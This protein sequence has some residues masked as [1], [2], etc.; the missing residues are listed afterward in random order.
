[1][2]VGWQDPAAIRETGLCVWRSG[3][4]PVLDFKQNGDFLDGRMAIFWTGK[5][6]DTP[7]IANMPRDYNRIA[8]AAVVARAGAMNADIETLG[9][10]VNLQYATQLAEGM[11]SLPE[12]PGAIAQKYC[13]GGHGGYALYLFTDP[14]AR[15]AAIAAT[16]QL[17]AIEPIC[18]V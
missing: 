11:D 2:G 1:M 18:R 12:I 5:P 6:H 13:G 16:E 9:R 10:G 14:E 17:R 7:G 3:E 4:T 8:E 15:N